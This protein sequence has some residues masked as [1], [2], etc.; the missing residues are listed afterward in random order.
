M[1]NSHLLI[2]IFS[3]FG[4]GLFAS[5][6]PCVYP[7]LP[8]TIG[9]F[10]RGQ[11]AGKNQ[12]VGF[13]VIGQVIALTFI[14]YLAVSLGETFGFS[15]ESKWING[16]L[17]VFL[18]LMGLVSWRGQLPSFFN[19]WNNKAANLNHTQSNFGSFVLGV[20]SALV[21]SP[22]TTPILSG[23]LVM[24]ATSS[25]VVKGTSLM[26]FYSLGFSSLLA[27]ISLGLVNLK[28]LPQSG[29]W[30]E[31]VNKISSIVL[32]VAGAYYCF[33]VV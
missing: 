13:F 29:Q 27:L 2:Q 17:G 18:I 32:V 4:A 6:S 15:S 8:I 26:F 19:K 21:T 12:R 30:M 9:Y 3:S 5:L 10:G 25:T 7:M 11:L 16:F 31:W 28:K 14:G 33:R 20:G 23:V 1:E 22:C 24:M